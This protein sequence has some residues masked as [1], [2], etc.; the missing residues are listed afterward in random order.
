MQFVTTSSVNSAGDSPQRNAIRRANELTA[1]LRLREA[2]SVIQ[3][4]RARFPHDPDTLRYLADLHAMRG[5]FEEAAALYAELVSSP[6]AS[7]EDLFRCSHNFRAAGCRERSI[8]ALRRAIE[9]A[10]LDGR[11]WW[12]LARFFPEEIGEGDAGEIRAALQRT[13]PGAADSV[14][15]HIAVSIVCDRRGDYKSAFEAISRAKAARRRGV[16][17]DPDRFTG[18]IDGLISQFTPALSSCGTSE[19]AASAAP[20]FI[21]GMPR[22]G[23]TLVERILGCHSMI[24]G[25][26]EVQLMPRLLSKEDVRTIGSGGPLFETLPAEKLREMADWYL[27]RS[28]EFRRSDKPFFADK[29][30]ANWIHVGMIRLMFPEAKIIE[31]RRDPV[32]CCWSVFKIMFADAYASDQRTLARYFADYARFMDAMKK[33]AGE[34]IL[35][36]R[37]E[38]IVGDLEAQTRRMLGFLGLDYE[39][40]CADFHLSTAAVSTPSSEQVRRPLNRAGINAAAPYVHWLGPMIDELIERGVIDC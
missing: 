12:A 39:P 1:Q 31:V 17:Y 29:N 20:I 30:N 16:P 15:L 34:R 6:S 33:A 28:R 21:V 26:G 27:E 18:Y 11:A 2:L 13:S 19:G 10:P 7:V 36:V 14:L 23:S 38:D 32:D 9:I 5:D 4:L 25:L 8:A 3:E 40:A 37:Y 22:S 35:T 24:E